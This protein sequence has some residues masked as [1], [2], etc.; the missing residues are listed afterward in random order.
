MYYARNNLCSVLCT[1]LSQSVSVHSSL[2]LVIESVVVVLL[3]LYCSGSHYTHNVY[4]QGGDA[5]EQ[6]EQ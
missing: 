4:M 6:P 3:L 1:A 2:E 5:E